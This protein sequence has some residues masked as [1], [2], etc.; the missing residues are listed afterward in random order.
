[1]ANLSI[2]LALH[3]ALVCKIVVLVCAELWL[4]YFSNLYTLAEASTRSHADENRA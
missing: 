3:T 4:G 2:N 1:M